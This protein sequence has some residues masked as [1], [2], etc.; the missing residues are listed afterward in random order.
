MRRPRAAPGAGSDDTSLNLLAAMR[1]FV[2][3]VE[4]GTFSKAARDL[5]MGQPA[6]SERIA[7]LEAHLGLRL[8]NRNGRSLSC[9]ESGRLFHQL[10]LDT[11]NL[12][13]HGLGSLRALD[14]NLSGHLRIAA[15]VGF[16]EVLL[17]TALVRIR[18]SFPEL[19]IELQFDDGMIEPATEGVDLLIRLGPV[20]N[21]RVV[22]FE[23]CTLRHVLAC[24]PDYAARHGGLERESDF[25]GHPFLGMKGMLAGERL[26]LQPDATA[27]ADEARAPARNGDTDAGEL[28]IRTAMTANHWRPL[29]DMIEAGQGIGVLPYS[30]CRSLM[31]QG[32]LTRVL[33]HRLA[34]A[35]T[36]VYALVPQD[37]TSS[38]KIRTLV[39]IL[40]QCGRDCAAAAAAP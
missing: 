36:P 15:P 12:V 21:E 10:S 37:R 33:P 8:L 34:G 27:G 23:L 29:L 13:D 22:A 7:K 18:E 17:P 32:R 2:R 6:V 19:Q 1:A 40:Q 11:L 25:D 31:R 39:Q 3:I 20:G 35:P 9:T 30:L 28:E 26:A 5:D 38:R 4:R 24:T 14:T 16:G